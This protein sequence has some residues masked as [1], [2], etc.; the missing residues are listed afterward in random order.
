M[1]VILQI[2]KLNRSASNSF[3]TLHEENGSEASTTDL[4]G[5]VTGLF[6][7]PDRRQFFRE[8]RVAKIAPFQLGFEKPFDLSL[9]IPTLGRHGES[10]DSMIESS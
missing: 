7:D 3:H 4:V 9:P 5:N 8:V 10:P 6:L 2:P 1:T